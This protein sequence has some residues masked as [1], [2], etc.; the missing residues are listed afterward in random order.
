MTVVADMEK[1]PGAVEEE[2]KLINLC[3]MGTAQE[4]AVRSKY[5]AAACVMQVCRTYASRA[6]HPRLKKERLMHRPSC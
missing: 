3:V 5:W 1:A 2:L 6:R 4:C